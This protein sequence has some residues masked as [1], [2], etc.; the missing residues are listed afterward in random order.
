MLLANNPFERGLEA[1]I[2]G[3]EPATCPYPQESEARRDWLDG[4]SESAI[5]WAVCRKRQSKPAHRR[6][7]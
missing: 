7:R 1:F 2:L 4:F 6:P 5:W 3:D